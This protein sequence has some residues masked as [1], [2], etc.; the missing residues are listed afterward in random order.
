MLLTGTF[1]RS[2][3]EK[4]RV[5]IPKPIRDSFAPGVPG[6]LYIAPGMDGSL[7]LYPEETFGQLAQRL[8]QASP[9]AREVREYSRMF[10]AQ[11]VRVEMDRQGRIRIPKELIDLVGLGG[12][13]VL[14]GVQDHLELWDKG[15]WEAYLEDRLT[16]YDEIAEAA[17][18]GGA[19]EP[20][21][22]EPSPGSLRVPK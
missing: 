11:S 3:D 18:C 6:V 16:R 22:R 13:V 1:P 5:A 21:S 8:A 14:L 12:E 4:Q 9:T 15:R 7:A 10:Y 20:S 2:V 17:F 19:V